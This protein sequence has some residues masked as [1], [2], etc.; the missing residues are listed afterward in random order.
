MAK[1][2]EYLPSKCKTLIQTPSLPKK[3]KKRERDF[4]WTLSPVYSW[5]VIPG[6][7]GQVN[8][9]RFGTWGSSI[10]NNNIQTLRPLSDEGCH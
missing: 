2:I 1:V 7:T 6:P 10:H 3:K 4:L 8:R 5:V 9:R